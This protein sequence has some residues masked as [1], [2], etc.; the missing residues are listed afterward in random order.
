MPLRKSPVQSMQVNKMRAMV[1]L[2]MMMMVMMMMMMI[3]LMTLAKLL[4]QGVS[5]LEG[6]PTAESL[7]SP[8]CQVL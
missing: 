4:V 5:E 3:L 6:A 2:M 1:I 8:P 7:K